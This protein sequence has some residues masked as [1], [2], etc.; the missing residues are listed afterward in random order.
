[1]V[2]R[3]VFLHSS[4]IVQPILTKFD[5]FSHNYI[6]YLSKQRIQVWMFR[7]CHGDHLLRLNLTKIKGLMTFLLKLDVLLTF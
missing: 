6:G 1:M 2:H 4:E 3:Q 5:N 7:C